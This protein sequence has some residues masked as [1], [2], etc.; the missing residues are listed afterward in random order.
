MSDTS[1][2]SGQNE[3]HFATDF[4]FAQI[5]NRLG[6]IEI[7]VQRIERQVTNIIY[8]GLGILGLEAL[9]VLIVA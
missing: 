7:F 1:R 6:R 9:R 5:E 8:I 3:P 4:W 2:T